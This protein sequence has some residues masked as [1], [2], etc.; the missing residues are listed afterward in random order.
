MITRTPLVRSSTVYDF[1]AAQR[2]GTTGRD[3]GSNQL[4]IQDSRHVQ[5]PRLLPPG[6]VIEAAS[7]V[8]GDL[9]S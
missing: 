1:G 3:V 8:S 4:H 5:P 7:S 6:I 9:F 2:S